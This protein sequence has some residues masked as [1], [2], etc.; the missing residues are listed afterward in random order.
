MSAGMRE[1]SQKYSQNELHTIHTTQTKTGTIYSDHKREAE[2][3]AQK[4]TQNKHNSLKLTLGQKVAPGIELLAGLDALARVAHRVTA[5]LA[6]LLPFAVRS[7]AHPPE[8]RG[9]FVSAWGRKWKLNYSG[10]KN[11]PNF[12][13]KLT[14]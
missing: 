7:D 1:K 4:N 9:A 6:D 14:I 5:R 12:N 10:Y 3:N 11:S 13:F 2:E 8:L